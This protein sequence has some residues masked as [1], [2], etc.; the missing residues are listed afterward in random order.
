[1]NKI[2]IAIIDD[3]DLFRE[4]ITLIVNQIGNFNVVFD[5][6]NG[7][8]FLEYLNDNP[9]PDITLMDIQ[10]PIIDGIN[11]TR[12]AI[13]LYPDIK[14][15]ALTLFS[16]TYHYKK[17]IEAGAR[18][19]MLKNAQKQEL[20]LAIEQVASGRQY[21][22]QEIL[23]KLAFQAGETN[24]FED[25]LSKRESQILELICHGYTTRQ[26]GEKLCISP[27]TVEGH[28]SNIFSKTNVSNLAELIMW[29]IKN[30]YISFQ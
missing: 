16:D 7:N 21:I 22:S 28:R 17:M 18:G 1:M 24:N 6:N 27:K 20:Q 15:I 11:T 26:I 14:I 29:A 13:K 5:S 8:H 9:L 4:G 10:M 25:Q 19:F 30:N 12:E 3:H 23:Q 2:N